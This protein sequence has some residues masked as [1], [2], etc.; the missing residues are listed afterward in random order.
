MP[1]LVLSVL[2]LLAGLTGTGQSQ[3]QLVREDPFAQL[4]GSLQTRQAA[5]CDGE[6]LGLD[7]PHGSKVNYIVKGETAYLT[8]MS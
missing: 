5:A 3:Y 4:S 1:R 2:V 6:I 8:N 7:C